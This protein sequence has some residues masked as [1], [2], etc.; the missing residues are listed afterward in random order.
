MVTWPRDHE[1]C[2]TCT[3]PQIYHPILKLNYM[4]QSARGSSREERERERHETRPEAV[5]GSAASPRPMFV[6][7]RSQGKC[8]QSS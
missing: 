8:L 6:A 4:A 5:A 2:S 1:L 3:R 7:R